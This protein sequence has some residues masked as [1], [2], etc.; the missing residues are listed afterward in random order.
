MMDFTKKVVF[1]N[2]R[3]R[4][5][6]LIKG[7]EVASEVFYGIMEDEYDKI[8]PINKLNKQPTQNY[9]DY[10]DN[11]ESNEVDLESDLDLES[12]C[13]CED[14]ICPRCQTVHDI[15]AEI[16]ECECYEE[17]FEILGEI[18]DELLGEAYDDGMIQGIQNGAQILSQV[19]TAIDQ[20]LY[21]EE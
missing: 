7:K 11:T 4:E 15:L 20:G 8:N 16:A 14:E 19:G 5:T 6:F 2:G 3:M 1:E 10:Y 12:D 17:R 18:L 9:N 13:D 21:E